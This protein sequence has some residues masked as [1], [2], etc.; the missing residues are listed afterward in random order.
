MG[1]RMTV[2]VDPGLHSDDLRQSLYN[3]NLVILTHLSAVSDFV[4]YTRDQLTELF[5]PYDP[6]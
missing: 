3:G 4:E 5:K 6:E 2:F 1:G